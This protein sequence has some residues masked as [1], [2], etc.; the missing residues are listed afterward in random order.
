ME[1]Y[2]PYWIREHKLSVGQ[3][4]CGWNMECDIR[5]G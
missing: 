3:N 5:T 2:N 1:K 4:R